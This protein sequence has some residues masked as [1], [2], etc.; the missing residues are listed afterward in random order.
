VGPWYVIKIDAPSNR[1]V[2]GR[3]EELAV[4]EVEL[5]DVSFIAGVVSEPV[6]CEA[7]LRYHSQLIPAKYASGRLTLDEPF[8]GA[9]PGQAAV[10]Y[11]GTKVLGGGTIVRAL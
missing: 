11:A 4:R 6:R 3:R 10:L 2:V 7:R 9:A 1:L 8:L 5:R